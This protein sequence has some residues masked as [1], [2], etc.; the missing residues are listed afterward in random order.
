MLML[1]AVLA[2]AL[3]RPYHLET[4]DSLRASRHTHVQVAGV[5]TLVRHERDGDWHLV[6]R[7]VHG[8]FVVAEIV[9]YHPL[10]RPLVGQRI[11]VFGIRRIDN[12][13]GHGWPE[14]HPVEKWEVSQ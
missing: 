8:H 9:P 10:P 3:S 11:V 6:L 13:A 4:V 14:I 5:V 7:D 2:L 12:E 1:A